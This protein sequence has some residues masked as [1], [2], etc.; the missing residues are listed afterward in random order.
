MQEKSEASLKEN[1]LNANRQMVKVCAFSSIIMAVIWLL[2]IFQFFKM[3]DYTLIHIISPLIIILLLTPLFVQKTKFFYSPKFKYY[4]IFKYIFVISILNI[5]IPKHA[6]LGWASILV[7]ANHYYDHKFGK[8]VFG[9]VLFQMLL[10]I[11]LAMFFGEYDCNI[12]TPGIIKTDDHGNLYTYEPATPQERW[13]FLTDLASKGNPFRYNR[14][15]TAFVYYFSSR[16]VFLTIIFFISNGL[17]IRTQKLL[18]D[19]IRIHSEKSSMEAELNLAQQ[20]QIA[21][22]PEPFENTQDIEILAEVNVA[23][24]VG[25][26]FYDYFH[27]DDRHIGVLIGDVSG[28][29]SPAAMFMMKTITCFNNFVEL[30]K[31]PS[32]VMKE[33]NAYIYKGNDKEMFVTC[34]YGVLDLDTG[35]FEF[36]NAGHNRP[37]IKRNGKYLYLPCSSGFVLGGLP[38]AYTKDEKTTLDKGDLIVL[39]TDGVTEA[40]NKEGDFYGENRLIDFYNSKTF[41]SLVEM[42][43]ELKDDIKS[44]VNGAPQND[45]MTLLL[46]KYQGDEVYFKEHVYRDGLS[47]MKDISSFTEAALKEWGLE[48]KVDIN[49]NVVIDEI[50]SNICKYAYTDAF[51]YVYVRFEYN[52]TKNQISLTF[53]D[54]G[55]PFNQAAVEENKLE[56]DASS[57]NEGGLGLLIVKNYMDVI[58]YNRSNDK[59]ILI[60]R[61]NIK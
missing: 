33:V 44:F 57:F 23:K 30:G 52:K 6:L 34:F 42:Q 26:D 60:M 46:M 40:R 7:L 61:K 13:D 31:K 50:F 24:E 56:G 22:L 16:A 45:D 3:Y 4:V 11:Y 49:I 43:Y 59:N 32:Q 28:K 18:N 12:M 20:V 38:E 9:V 47:D 48:K 55:V 36:A 21:A 51:D 25:G 29:G 15:L 17:N 8:I 1:E 41:T 53:V 2:Y 10:C 58:Q 27:L 54:R 5:V 35:V 19:Q 14:F 39:Y 37:I